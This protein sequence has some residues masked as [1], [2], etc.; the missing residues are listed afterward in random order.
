MMFDPKDNPQGVGASTVSMPAM[1][2]SQSKVSLRDLPPDVKIGD[3]VE[4]KV[5][6]LDKAGNCAYVSPADEDDGSADA[7]DSSEETGD[8]PDAE[9]N[10]K[11]AGGLDQGL[12]T[13]PM[14]KLKNYLAQKSVDHQSQM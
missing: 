6:S 10:E 8:T 1:S 9:E 7:D 13:G 11:P 2:A 5:K 4:L 3:V 14:G 12:L